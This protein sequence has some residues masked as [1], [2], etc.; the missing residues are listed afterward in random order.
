MPCQACHGR[1][2]ATHA[3]ICDVM[4]SYAKICEVMHSHETCVVG[5]DLVTNE[6]AFCIL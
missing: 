1:L 2:P 3:Q 5:A 6:T 4:S